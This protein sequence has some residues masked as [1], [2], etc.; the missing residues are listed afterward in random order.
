MADVPILEVRGL[1]KSFGGIVTAQELT[2]TL[3]PERVTALVGPNGAGKTTFFNMLSGYIRPES[4]EILFESRS[5][6]G[7]RPHEIA[8]L[9]IG[10]S[11]QDVRIFSR[12]SVL[13]NVVCALDAQPGEGVGRAVFRPFSVGAATK[14]SR[15]RAREHLDFVNLADLADRRAENLSYGQQKRLAL[16]R[17][18]AMDCRLLLLDEPASGLDPAALEAMLETIRATMALGK[19]ICLIEH[20]LDVVTALSDWLLFLDRGTLVAEGAP[21]EILARSDL[22]DLYFGSRPPQRDEVGG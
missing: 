12:L 6:V 7:K 1:R 2:V 15:K 10:R 22:S 3:Q 21:A 19:T 17:L 13:D 4:G 9:G 11:F 16:A 5:I 8:K 20:N 14:R 18:L